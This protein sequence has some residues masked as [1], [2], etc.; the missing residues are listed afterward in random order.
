MQLSYFKVGGVWT[1]HYGTE[2]V[3]VRV[4]N[5]LKPIASLDLNAKSFGACEVVTIGDSTGFGDFLSIP[6]KHRV[7]VIEVCEAEIPYD[8]S[9]RNLLL[10]AASCDVLYGSGD[11]A[12][13]LVKAFA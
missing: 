6:G 12:P 8:D 11:L 9:L 1:K 3:I 7:S 10:G 5:L 13:E 2:R 4:G